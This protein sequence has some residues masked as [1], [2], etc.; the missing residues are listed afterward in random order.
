MNFITI[1]DAALKW[2]ITDRMVQ[3][4]CKEGEM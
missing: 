4:Y 2:G 3:N 1:K